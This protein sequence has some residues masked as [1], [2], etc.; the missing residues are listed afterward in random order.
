MLLV[1]DH[2]VV[3]QGLKALLETKPDITFAGEASNGHDAVSLVESLHP[4]VMVLDLAMPGM[5]GLEVLD[6]L[7][8]R[9][10]RQHVLVLSM[11]GDAAYVHES[12]RRGAGGYVLK[13]APASELVA[14][15]RAVAAG[16]RYLG[17]SGAEAT[18]VAD[19]NSAGQDPYETLTAREKDV[20]VLLARPHDEGDRRAAGDRL[21]HRGDPPRAPHTQAR[22]AGAWRP[23]ALRHAL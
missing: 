15:V 20:L 7:R 9:G 19:D 18:D 21:A 16:E 8:R 1:D 13:E 3:R 22:P 23:R 12:M 14:G 4:D 2:E 17:A 10:L 5:S 11:Y 6:E